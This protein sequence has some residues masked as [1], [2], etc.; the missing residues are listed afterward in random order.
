MYLDPPYRPIS[1]TSGFTAYNKEGF[2]DKEQYQLSKLIKKIN[3]NNDLFILSNSSTND[4][5]LKDLYYFYN[6]K[7]IDA[8]RS[9][10]SK[11]N[12]RG[13]VKELLISNCRL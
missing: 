9:I 3:D 5:F 10:N 2:G 13:P 12:K 6:I 4:D 1:K 11:G 8:R 7:E